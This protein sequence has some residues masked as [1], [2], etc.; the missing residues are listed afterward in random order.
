MLLEQGFDYHL[1][2]KDQQQVEKIV[3]LHQAKIHLAFRAHVQVSEKQY[4]N[5]GVALS[6]HMVT[7]C[8][9]GFLG[10]SLKFLDSFHVFDII[11]VQTTSDD[12]VRIDIPNKILYISTTT[13]MRFT[14][15][16]L[17]N[18]VLSN[19]MLPGPMRFPFICHDTSHFPPF[20]PGLSPSQHFQFTYNAFCS[21]FDTSYYH[22][23]PMFFHHNMSTAN[24]IFDLTKL[25]LHILES[26]FGESADIRPITSSLM[27]CPYTYGFVCSSFARPD[28]IKASASLVLCNPNIKIIRLVDTGAETGCL[29][30]SNAMI[31]SQNSDVIYW[32]LSNNPLRDIEAF[33]SSL[34]KYKAEVQSIKLDNCGISDIALCSLFNSLFENDSMHSIRQVSVLYSPIGDECSELLCD[35]FDA[36]TED[37]ESRLEILGIGPVTSIGMV[38]AT[39]I[40]RDIQ[41]QQLTIVNTTFDINAVTTLS[42]YLKNAKLLKSLNLSGCSI[43]NPGLIQIINSIGSN[44]SISSIS[45][46]LSR[47]RLSK[48]RAHEIIAYIADHM[49]TQLS[50]LYLDENKMGLDELNHLI[51]VMPSFIALKKISLSGNFHY[52]MTGIGRKLSEL[53][54]YES[55]ESFIIRGSESLYLQGEIIPFICALHQ[56]SHVKEIDISMNSIGDVGLSTLTNLI[57]THKGLELI[58]ADGSNVKTFTT[59][60]KYFQAVFSNSH[61]IHAQ[62]PVEDIYTFISSKDEKLQNQFIQQVSAYQSRI[63][64]ALSTN[65]AEKSLHS[66]LSLLKDT[67]LD[68]IIDNSSIELQAKI[69]Q[70]QINE[71]LAITSI[72]GLPFPF[73]KEFRPS[74]GHRPGT[75]GTDDSSNYVDL[76]L[77]STIHEGVDQAEE[78]LKTLQFN[79]LC[80]RR[81][82]AAIRL[83]QK[84][85]VI[86]LK[87][88]QNEE[89]NEEEEDNQNLPQASVF[90]PIGIEENL[91]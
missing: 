83:A 42:E 68:E 33:T 15:N 76:T 50:H 43:S 52:K 17:R 71:H 27:F 29:E 66:D 63:E 40:E 3:P 86:S 91:Q 70:V 51:S 11:R 87:D 23:V 22:D 6:E 61:L 77:L 48:D 78:N 18:F 20:N 38:I 69:S 60:E 36:I 67:V 8:C 72:V 88:F 62:F 9:R 84:A 14:R 64:K 44:N 65:R 34:I 1:S 73:E 80:I 79:S 26:G 7:I 21:Y 19:P 45:L 58:S 39:M 2:P 31:S 54:Q 30:I 5:C 13:C 16:L 89:D 49:S 85:N 41:L 57:K 47:M 82:N 90:I 37:Q 55:I 35:F 46:D 12:C 56:S 81:P 25:P 59:M 32:D 28:I 75:D 74:T 53:L 4:K 24:A 10:N